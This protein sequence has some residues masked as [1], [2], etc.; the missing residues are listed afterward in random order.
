MPGLKLARD[1]HSEKLGG[2]M[3]FTSDSPLFSKTT[4]PPIAFNNVIYRI[5]LVLKDNLWLRMQPLK[6]NIW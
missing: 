4:P 6:K 2:I 1:A 3:F 5:G